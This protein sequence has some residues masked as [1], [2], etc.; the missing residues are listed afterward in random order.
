MSRAVNT[1]GAGPEAQPQRRR[2]D[3]KALRLAVHG[4]WL[5]NP[6]VYKPGSANLNAIARELADAGAASGA[7]VLDDADTLEA[8]G[9]GVAWATP[10]GSSGA[11]SHAAVHA[12]LIIRPALSASA[13]GV[14]A[15]LAVAEVAHDTFGRPCSVQGRWK[16]VVGDA[17][18]SPTR[19]GCTSVEEGDGVAFVDLRLMLAQLALLAEADAGLGTSAGLLARPD[20]R[21]VFLA[22][23]LHTFDGR[24]SAL[25]DP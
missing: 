8:Q 1:D 11:S 19:V 7:L 4:W 24:L 15:A 22:R 12:I 6:L 3:L 9:D 5:G 23:V 16:V 14:A 2:M 13:L 21:E 10:A 17:H 20:W 25:R 18:G